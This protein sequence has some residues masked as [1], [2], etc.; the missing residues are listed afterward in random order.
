MEHVWKFILDKFEEGKADFW[1]AVYSAVIIAIGVFVLSKLYKGTLFGFNF[2]HRNVVYIPRALQAYKK[3]LDEATLTIRHSWKLDDQDFEKLIVPVHFKYSEENSRIELGVFVQQCFGMASFPRLILKGEPGSGKSVAMGSIARKVWLIQRNPVLVPVLM[4]FSEVKNV[5]KLEDME[6]LIAQVLQR[7]QFEKG[8]R[9]KRTIHYVNKAL[10]SGQMLLLIDGFDELEKNTR[11]EVAIFLED[12]FKTYPQIPFVMSCRTAVWKDSRGA[13][14][15]LCAAE[16]S[17][18]RFNNNDIKQFLRAWNFQG[19]KSSEQLSELIRTKSYLQTIAENP[20]MLTIIAFLYAQPKRILPD[21]RVKFYQECVDALMEKFDNAKQIARANEFD[22]IHKNTILSHIAYKHIVGGDT[23]DGEIRKEMVLDS[24][25][26]VMEQLSRPPEKRQKMLDE[27]VQ[28][29]ELLVE[30]PPDHFKFPHRTFME[31]FAANYFHEENKVDELVALYENDP[32][33]W[34]ETVALFC[35]IN[36]QE[37]IALKCFHSAEGQFCRNKLT[38]T[39]NTFVFRI[40]V[41][42]AKVRPE[43]ALRLLESAKIFLENNFDFQL[44][45]Y[46]GYI[47][48]NENF[49][50]S[51]E[52]SN[53]LANKLYNGLNSKELT[54]LLVALSLNRNHNTN[55]VITKY[56]DAV[57]SDGLYELLK[58]DTHG[59]SSILFKFNAD[60]LKGFIATATHN[61]DIEI[62]L[63]ILKFSSNVEVKIQCAES[64]YH[65]AG[66]PSFYAR[67]SEFEDFIL[68]NNEDKTYRLFREWSWK[69]YNII[70]NESGKKKLSLIVHYLVLGYR[71][72]QE[73]KFRRSGLN[74]S[75]ILKYHFYAAL[76]NEKLYDKYQNVLMNCSIKKMRIF[77]ERPKCNIIWRNLELL[78]P[79]L[80]TFTVITPLFMIREPYGIFVALTCLGIP[81][82]ED[83][84]LIMERS[85]EFQGKVLLALITSFLVFSFR[86]V[87][88]NFCLSSTLGLVN[89]YLVLNLNI[90]GVIKTIFLMSFGI[91][92]IYVNFIKTGLLYFIMAPYHCVNL[93]L[94]PDSDVLE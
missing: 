77:W 39:P 86:S 32:R 46:L 88:L 13:F 84:S 90:N 11:Q 66:N 44:V 45:E 38:G 48:A 12:F 43:W 75:K 52:A 4:T 49:T 50:Y 67:L 63:K 53:I 74:Q 1:G 78:I 68:D 10:Y 27:I 28:N 73:A 37:G 35:G 33:K 41:E 85:L 65:N 40:L 72:S 61:S 22:T 58:Y 89:M 30:L 92:Y 8:K 29:T 26:S 9:T 76:N 81:F 34:E 59:M 55:E 23:T 93:L 51:N 60:K 57:D 6:G 47:G 62:L 25:K 64:L 3:S 94:D 87:I 91:I 42:S 36:L 56:I 79:I 18:M 71:I 17:M 80:S 14:A 5:R 21:N 16:I 82:V 15:E 31:F 2:L 20:L 7:N 70:I 83:S 69:R 54:S 19:H 24:V